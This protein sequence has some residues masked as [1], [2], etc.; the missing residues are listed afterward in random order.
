MGE[1]GRGADAP[2]GLPTPGGVLYFAAMR[3][4]APVLPCILLAAALAGAAE[5]APLER[6]FAGEGAA[7]VVAVDPGE[8]SAER[9]CEAVVRTEAEAPREARRPGDLAGRF[10]GFDAAGS[11]VDE[12]GALHLSLVP[13]PGAPRY[14]VKP[15]AVTVDDGRGGSSWFAT[16]PFGLPAAPAIRAEGDPAAALRRGGWRRSRISSAKSWYSAPV[17]VAA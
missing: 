3:I 7:V 13:R 17:M 15:F 14:R 4:H 6:R 2:G 8:V 11:Y 12:D 16:E 10:E 1:T 9:D 5:A